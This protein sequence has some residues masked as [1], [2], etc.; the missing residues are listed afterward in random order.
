MFHR[1]CKNIKSCEIH[2]QSSL[3]GG[4]YWWCKVKR[5][6]QAYIINNATEYLFS[7]ILCFI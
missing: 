4:A 7:T 6:G 5:S 3:G 1:I 2:K